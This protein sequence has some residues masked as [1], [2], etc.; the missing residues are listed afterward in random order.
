MHI[1][2]Q[3]GALVYT[4]YTYTLYTEYLNMSEKSAVGAETCGQKCKINWRMV[5]IISKKTW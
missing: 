2:S 5:S 1:Y 4:Y 3:K